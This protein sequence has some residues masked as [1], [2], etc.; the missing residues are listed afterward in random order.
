VSHEGL[1][2][3]APDNVMRWVSGAG[4]LLGL[5]AAAIMVSSL[6]KPEWRVTAHAKWASWSASSSSSR[7]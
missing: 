7:R 6:R 4:I 2:S 3:A 1:F 5:A